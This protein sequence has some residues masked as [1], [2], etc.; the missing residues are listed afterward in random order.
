MY[1]YVGSDLSRENVHGQA[2]DRY[3]LDCHFTRFYAWL[4]RSSP[5]VLETRLV[6][7]PMI[8]A[9]ICPDYIQSLKNNLEAVS[10]PLL[11]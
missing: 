8:L 7:M 10:I 9:I 4:A 6:T 1:V 3:E 2:N 5:W 11:T